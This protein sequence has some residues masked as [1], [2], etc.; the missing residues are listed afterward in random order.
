MVELGE[1]KM[2]KRIRK[3]VEQNIRLFNKTQKGIIIESVEKK[4]DNMTI[5]DVL[6][7]FKVSPAVY[8]GWI[9]NN[10]KPTKTEKEGWD[11]QLNGKTEKEGLTLLKKLVQIF[12][13]SINENLPLDFVNLE[14]NNIK[15]TCIKNKC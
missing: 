8:Y 14:M 6:N 1:I 2:T 10:I 5:E 4:P 15:L 11:I 3:G 9:R 7:S 13:V 12:E